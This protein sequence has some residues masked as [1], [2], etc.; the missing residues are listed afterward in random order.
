M[1]KLA[2]AAIGVVAA[3][4]GP[5]ATYV[6]MQYR[7]DLLEGRVVALEAAA[8]DVKC[9]ICDQHEIRCPGC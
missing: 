9:M 8:D 1:V 6:I 5:F 4:A 3:I 7:V 2:G